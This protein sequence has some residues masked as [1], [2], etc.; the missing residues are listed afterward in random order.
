MKWD[1]KDWSNLVWLT[2]TIL[3]V[4]FELLGVYR[5]GPWRTL[6]ET[7]WVDESRFHILY[8]LI[9]GFVCGLGL[10]FSPNRLNF[11]ESMGAGLIIVTVAYLLAYWPK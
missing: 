3:C 7:I 11:F 6:S 10:H 1:W 8:L 4:T 2:L 9:G 5:I